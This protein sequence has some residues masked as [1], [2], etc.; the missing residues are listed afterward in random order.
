MKRTVFLAVGLLALGAGGVLA[1]QVMFALH[2]PYP[3]PPSFA[4]DPQLKV[5]LG[6][7]LGG[8][9]LFLL[10]LCAARLPVLGAGEAA[11]DAGRTSWRHKALVVLVLLVA[12]AAR[13]YRVTEV[14]PPLF[15]DEA[16]TALDAMKYLE[17]PPGERTLIGTGWGEVPYAYTWMNSFALQWFGPT[18][19]GARATGVV[20]STLTALVLY[21]LARGLTGSPAVAL[22]VMFA[23]ALQRWHFTMGRFAAS[24]IALPLFACLAFLFISRGF[25]LV[26]GAKTVARYL[27]RRA[28]RGPD[29]EEAAAARAE[30]RTP[31]WRWR[32]WALI[33]GG[34]FLGAAMYI[35]LASRLVA[36]G[37][38]VFL[39]YMV[40]H[41]WGY[42]LFHRRWVWPLVWRRLGGAVVVG[43]VYLAVFWPMYRYYQ[44]H[45]GI[46]TNRWKDISLPK[47]MGL[48]TEPGKITWKDVNWERV[49]WQPFW[50]NVLS[51]PL[52]LNYAGNEVPRYQWP[53]TPVLN[54]VEGWLFALGMVCLLRHCW[55][56]VNAFCLMWVLVPLAGGMITVSESP[57]PFRTIVTS[58]G[59][60]LVMLI[61][62][63]YLLLA[64][65]RL[66]E[67]ASWARRLAVGAAAVL[68][69]GSGGYN[70]YLYWGKQIHHPQLH[71][72]CNYPE[73][74][75]AEAVR[76]LPDDNP[77]FLLPH[78]FTFSSVKL[79]NWA[80]R[81]DDPALVDPV[82]PN[83]R[84]NVKMFIA[85]QYIPL[86]LPDD[87]DVHLFLGLED[88]AMLEMLRPFHPRAAV[89][90]VA[91]EKAPGYGHCHFVIPGGDLA[92]ARGWRLMDPQPRR[93]AALEHPDPAAGVRDATWE[94]DLHIP[95]EG[96]YRF[97]LRSTAPLDDRCFFI[98]AERAV[99]SAEQTHHLLAGRCAV[100]LVAR[101]MAPD[102]R[103]TVEWQTPGRD[104]EPLPANRVY[105]FDGLGERGLRGSYFANPHLAG[106]PVMTR[107]DL[108]PA[109]APD[110]ALPWQSHSVRWEGF[111]EAPVAGAY[112]LSIKSDDGSRL[113]INGALLIDNWGVHGA[114]LRSGVVQLT[115][116]RHALMIEYFDQ[117]GGRTME[118]FW[119]TPHGLAG[120]VP[121]QYLTH[122]PADVT[123]APFR[124]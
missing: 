7:F 8:M 60:A 58:T 117:G 20:T 46:F 17:R 35:Y 56:P 120:L 33:A 10:G 111:L 55:R 43:L 99:V 13:S 61:P 29:S 93:V 107:I 14:P 83:A 110:V 23:F 5:S 108:L 75:V 74:A 40:L 87:A 103:L 109:A 31:V 77:I 71:R 41:S 54:V 48:E 79:L 118:F 52:M 102:E 44:A 91:L 112:S 94:A 1:G 97:R 32:I 114:E 25:D 15:D 86:M 67:G 18:V 49:D 68:L 16:N 37:V 9:A 89:T 106:E 64:L 45:P 95:R 19:W 115:Q 101:G 96:L 38:C 92:A 84:P 66:G 3:P 123:L 51:Y 72:Y 30:A 69:T 104:W 53:Y 100:R 2:T 57:S 98:A 90:R 39:V 4:Q 63:H 80:P 11:P 88:A 6:L 21:F 59:V 76:A 28:I 119:A 47:H 65:G 122:A 85:S 70:L 78:Y 12:L 124:E 113:Y 36:L 42:C 105:A 34:A 27:P 81:P 24:Q 73:F 50:L 82:N 22:L 26:L 121:F 62:L 116:G